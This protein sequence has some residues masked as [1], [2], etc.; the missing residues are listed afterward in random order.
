[1]NKNYKSYSY[2]IFLISVVALAFAYTLE[3]FDIYPCR[4]C[5]YQRYVYY[6]LIIASISMFFYIK[7]TYNKVLNYLELI[8][9]FL[10]IV[11]ISIGIFQVLIEKHIIHYESSCSTSMGSIASPEDL[12]TSINSK[13]LIACDI[14]QVE[15]FNLSLGAWNVIYM[16]FIL[17]SSLLI[18]YKIRKN[19]LNDRK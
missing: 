7:K 11:G 16:L 2:F 14:P 18:M 4:L 13:D 12:L 3:S 9:Y 1:M 10:L 8:V 5:I 6:G 15:I 19:E 17:C